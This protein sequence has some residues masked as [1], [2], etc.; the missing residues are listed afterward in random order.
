MFGKIGELKKM[1]DKYK[2]LQKALQK[3]VIRAKEGSFTDGSEEQAQII[4]DISGEMKVQDI[5]INDTSLLSPNHKDV[6]EKKLMTAVSKAQTKAQEVVQ[7]KTK[8]I[9]GFDPSDMANMM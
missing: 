1:Y 7:E 4:V 3:L 6:L 8:E 2:T 9:L 5:K